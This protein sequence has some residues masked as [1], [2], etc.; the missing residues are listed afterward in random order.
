MTEPVF[1]PRTPT[2]IID[3]AVRLYRANL[4]AFATVSVVMLLPF[5]I[6]GEALGPGWAVLVGLVQG[7]VTPIVIAVL[8]GVV[9]DVL[10]GRPASTSA[11]LARLRGRMGLI[12]SIAIAQGILTM[13]GLVLL[14]V[15][16]LIAMVWT[17]AAPMTVVIEGVRDVGTAFSRARALARGHFGHVLGT[18]MLTYLGMFLV[19]FALAVGLGIVAGLLHLP[20]HLISLLGSAVFAVIFPVVAVASTMLYFDLRVRSDAYDL[21]SMIAQLP[22]APVVPGAGAPGSTPPS[23]SPRAGTM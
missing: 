8:V 11:A 12:V 23:E 3:A 13:L 5:N 21:E 18:L 22:G 4:A 2:E 10:H 14:V 20:T 15:P 19:V 17:F 16:G 6:L 1:R 9:D 7:L